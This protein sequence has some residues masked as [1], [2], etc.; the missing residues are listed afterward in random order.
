MGKKATIHGVSKAVIARSRVY[1]AALDELGRGGMQKQELVEVVMRKLVDEPLSRVTVEH[2][3]KGAVYYGLL[4]AA[5]NSGRRKYYPPGS[6]KLEREY[7]M[8]EGRESVANVLRP[9]APPLT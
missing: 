7:N 2:Y 3:L 6:I 5:G 1:R 8:R 9:L 4:D